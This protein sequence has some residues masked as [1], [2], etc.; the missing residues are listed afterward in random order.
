VI[1]QMGVYQQFDF[2]KKTSLYILVNAV[3]NSAAYTRVL[4][5]CSSHQ[6]QMLLNPLW[7]HSVIHASYFMRWRDY[8][9][10]Y[11]SRLL[12]IV[13]HDCCSMMTRS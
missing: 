2:R 13:S 11:E 9:A 7:L 8:I 5:S 1:R 12:P 4:E 6:Q 3:P 10:E